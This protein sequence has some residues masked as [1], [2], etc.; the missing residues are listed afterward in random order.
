[1]SD[2]LWLTSDSRMV[3]MVLQV[4]LIAREQRDMRHDMLEILKNVKR[5]GSHLHEESPDRPKAAAAEAL[6][7]QPAVARQSTSTRHIEEAAALSALLLAIQGLG[8]D[9][10]VIK[11]AV[12]ANNS[13]AAGKSYNSYPAA[14]R[15]RSELDTT[16]AAVEQDSAATQQPEL[17]TKPLQRSTR[18]RAASLAYRGRRTAQTA[19]TSTPPPTPPPT[20]VHEICSDRG[21]EVPRQALGVPSTEPPRSTGKSSRTTATVLA[22][23]AAS[24][25]EGCVTF[26][27]P[28]PSPSSMAMRR[29]RAGTFPTSQGPASQ[30]G[31]CTPPNSHPTAVWDSVVL[32]PGGRQL[33]P[34]SSSVWQSERT[35]GGQPTRRDWPFRPQMARSATWAVALAAAV[36]ND[37]D[38]AQTAAR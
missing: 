4:F 30:G 29:G 18:N 27:T 7:V 9:I 5:N 28:S 6:S 36:D 15:S 35:L 34:F 38:M 11:L 2:D 26:P 24:S 1:M 20:N 13:K 25:T 16:V 3:M 31:S 33:L 37:Q 19:C 8:E 21:Q 10:N 22:V 14:S 32:V 17:Q 12:S 23:R